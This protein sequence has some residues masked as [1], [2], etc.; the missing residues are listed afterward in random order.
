MKR[1]EIYFI[2]KHG[3]VGSETAK[4]R[5]GV[6]VSNN[7]LN[8]TSD[9]VEVVYLTTAPKKDMPTHAVIHATGIESTVLC[10]HIDHVSK[11]LVGDF[12]GICSEMEMQEIEAALLVSLGIEAPQAE[13][14]GVY[15]DHLMDAVKQL[16]RLKAERDRYAKM[17]DHLLGAKE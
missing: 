5:P 12:C 1:G 8:A 11:T 14:E 16:E 2:Q 3:A 10:E 6:I 4:S 15:R 9:V 17:V 7:V 13:Q